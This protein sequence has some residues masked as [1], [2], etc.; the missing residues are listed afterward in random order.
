MILALNIHGAPFSSQASATA[1]RFARAALDAGHHIRRVFFFHDGVLNGNALVQPPQDEESP[2]AG[3][4][5]LAAANG[6]ELAVCVA[7]AL[8]RGVVDERERERYELTASNLHP[9]FVLVGLGQLIEAMS[10]CD[11]LVTFAP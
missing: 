8:K 10:D 5:A 7:T 2:Q 1:L 11:R 4:V 6:M 3:W 9:A